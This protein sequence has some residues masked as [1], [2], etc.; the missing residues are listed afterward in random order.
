MW[1]KKLGALLAIWM[2]SVTSFAEENPYKILEEV[3]GKTFESIKT[4]Q[5]KIK[6][7]P[8]ILKDIVEKELLPY[9]DYKFAGAKVLGKRFKSVPREKIPVFFEEFRKYL[10]ATYAGA[11]ALY[12]GQTV[13]FEPGKSFEGKKAVTVRAV[14]SE[15]GRP[16]IKVAFKVRRSSKTKEWRV[17]DME[18]EGISMLSSKRSEFESILRQEGIDKIIAIM[19]EKNNQKINLKEDV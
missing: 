5:A 8:E 10:I 3:A 2:F 19:Q 4:Q 16:D 12:E 18:A 11:L 9:T 14:I 17:W 6:K 1:F 13:E 7:N 15:D